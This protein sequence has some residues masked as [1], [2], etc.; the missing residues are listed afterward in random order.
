MFDRVVNAPRWSSACLV[1]SGAVLS[2][3]SITTPKLPAVGDAHVSLETF[4]AFVSCLRRLGELVPLSEFSRRR[5]EGR[6]T[7]GLIAITLDDAYAALAGEF[8]DFIAREAV[9]IAVFLINRAAATGDAFWWDRLDDLYPRVSP[10]RW[11]RFETACGLPDEFRRGPLR[12]LGPLRPLRQWLLSAYRGRWP[13]HLEPL[14]HGLEEEIGFQTCHRAMSFDDLGTLTA[15]PSVEVGVHTLSHPVLP[16]LSD[17]ELDREIGAAYKDLRDR[18]GTA[19]P[20]LAIPFG[21]YDERTLRAAERA[22]MTASLTLSA[23]M[24]NR[25]S[26]GHALPRY[27]VTRTDTPARLALRLS[28]VP[29]LMRSCFG[30][31]SASYPLLPSATS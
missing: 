22:G 25:H 19:L 15:L 10:V 29:R 2:F 31:R 3:H 13:D 16:L 6:S 14:L 1:P 12:S 5:A 7:S 28:G 9:P 21:L 27:C 17:S 30:M 11:R 8:R 4:R 26:I 23:D 20:I 24:S 18:C